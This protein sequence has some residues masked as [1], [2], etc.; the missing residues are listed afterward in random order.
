MTPPAPP[1]PAAPVSAFLPAERS[2]SDELRRQI[3]RFVGQPLATALLD[4]GLGYAMALNR[5]RQIVYLNQGLR[6]LLRERGGTLELGQRPGE[7][8]DCTHATTGPGGC[9]TGEACRCCGAA[10][11][12]AAALRNRVKVCECRLRTG[13]AGDDLTLQVK[14]TP[15]AIDAE[16]Y[17]I[18][19]AAD[20]SHEKRR[21]A[22]ER[23][24]FHD[25]LNTAGS[26]NGLARLMETEPT[27]DAARTYAPLLVAASHSLLD[28]IAAQR[29]LAA[30][31]SDELQ[32][33]VQAIEAT[34]LLRELAA[35][36]NAHVVGLGR[37]VAVAEDSEAFTLTSDPRLL[38]RVLANLLKNALE[39]EPVG[40]TVT[41]RARR[42][43][44]RAQFEVH[45]PAVMPRQVQ[46]QVFQRS[47]ST[48]GKERGLGTYSIRLLSERF[49]GGR[50]AFTSTAEDGTRFWVDYPLQLGGAPTVSAAGS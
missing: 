2:S 21:R 47:F 33:H 48:K 12:I 11:C 26:I 15:L 7:L 42:V 25:I 44:G 34:P 16:P 20:V 46:L 3:D 18:L 23:V 27:Y 41:I 39:A 40:S 32:V 13:E 37:T 22:L 10:Q 35:V 1:A 9:G 28:D 50:V 5:H 49:L 30:A 43:A 8:L 6:E 31:E 19:S 45:N 17:V 38:A 29:D 4:A 24:F 36:C 14:G